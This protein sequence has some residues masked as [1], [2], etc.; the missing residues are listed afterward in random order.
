MNG[1][2]VKKR[3]VSAPDY[4]GRCRGRFRD[5]DNEACRCIR[6][7]CACRWELSKLSAWRDVDSARL[8]LGADPPFLHRWSC[9]SIGRIF[10]RVV[11]MSSR[12]KSRLCLLCPSVH[13]SVRSSVCASVVTVVSVANEHWRRPCWHASSLAVWPFGRFSFVGQSEW[14]AVVLDVVTRN[15][16]HWHTRLN[17]DHLP[18]FFLLS[19]GLASLLSPAVLFCVMDRQLSKR[20]DEYFYQ[21]RESCWC[22]YCSLISFFSFPLFYWKNI[23][24][25]CVCVSIFWSAPQPTSIAAVMS[26]VIQLSSWIVHRWITRRLLTEKTSLNVV[27]SNF[28]GKIR[29]LQISFRLVPTIEDGLSWIELNE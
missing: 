24:C 13:P 9:L 25:V 12:A 1:K 22:D 3:N 5:N 20:R 2:I 15:W 16:R 4:L 11:A 26:R 21:K 8:V 14:V 17:I 10:N 19:V 7:S 28:F 29:P 27:L 23:V 18:F 6:Q